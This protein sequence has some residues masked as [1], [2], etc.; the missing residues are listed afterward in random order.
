MSTGPTG[1]GLFE[2]QRP[3]LLGVA[4][5]MV[6]TVADAEDI[7]QEAWL[8][9]RQ[10]D[11]QSL[12]CPEAWLTTVTT[13]LALDRLRAGRRRREDYV[14][15]WLP[16]PLVSEPGPEESAELAETL[17]LGFLTLLD[18]LSPVERAVFIL[19][20]IFSV[21]YADIAASVD[22]SSQAC[23]QIASRARRRIRT[24]HR[25]PRAA[26]RRVVD[27]ILVALAQGDVDAVVSRLAP[28]VV[29][30]SDGGAHRRAARHPVVG[31]TRVARFL[32]NL[33]TRYA[34]EFTAAAVN[35]NGDPGVVLAVNGEVDLVAAFETDGDRVSAIRIIRN[36]DKLGRISERLG[37]R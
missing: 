24:S 7:V 27:D 19:A 14:G 6:G 3:R 25:P 28:E 2:A 34:G 13:R 4:Y 33:A 5:R 20:D 8:R 21:P 17:T 1:P 32:T 18:Q 36:P 9:W 37:L 29:C 11:Q 26:D 30:V 23:R 31:A 15:P 16:E 35:V 10:A 12:A 22:K